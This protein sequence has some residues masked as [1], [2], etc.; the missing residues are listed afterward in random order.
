MF[1]VKLGFSY[2]D[3]FSGH[4][5]LTDLSANEKEEQRE[6]ENERG[7]SGKERTKE[8]REGERE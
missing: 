6:R 8:E 1:F 3:P 2:L 4:P 5:H 7:E